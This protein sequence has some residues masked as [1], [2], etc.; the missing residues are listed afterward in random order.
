M[1][2]DLISRDAV[3]DACSQ[4]INILDA[5]SRIEDLP[6]V[7][8]KQRWIPVSE[9]LPERNGQYLVTKAIGDYTYIG[10]M[11]YSTNLA[12][13]DKFDFH[14]KNYAGWYE[15]D[16]EYGFLETDGI[17]A[18]MPLPEPYKGESEDAE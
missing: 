17:I 9:R 1:N 12:K 5:M 13:T 7:T 18:W 4:S 16:M 15:Y 10:C 3:L 11:D 2:D 14:G 6:G 8:P